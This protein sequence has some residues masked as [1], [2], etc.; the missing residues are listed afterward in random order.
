MYSEKQL[1]KKD[2]KKYLKRISILIRRDEIRKTEEKTIPKYRKS[3][4]NL[5]ETTWRHERNSIK[6]NEFNKKK[7]STLNVKK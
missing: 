6:L 4:E 1:T 3:N 7:K 2:V 5:S